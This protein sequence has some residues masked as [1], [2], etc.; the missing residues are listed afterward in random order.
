M[1]RNFPTLAALTVVVLLAGAAPA[2]ADETRSTNPFDWSCAWSYTR[3]GLAA[4]LGLFSFLLAFGV[5]FPLLLAPEADI[6]SAWWPRNAF[7]VTLIAALALCSLW[8]QVFFAWLVNDLGLVSF[9]YFPSS[10]RWA[11]THGWQ[12]VLWASWA[13]VALLVWAVLR[14]RDRAPAKK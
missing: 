9:K 13:A 1:S 5:L 2:L 4:A 11:N 10:W 7:A 3:V 12:L 14:H 6:K 8:F